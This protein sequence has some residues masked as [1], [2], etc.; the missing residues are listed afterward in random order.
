MSEHAVGIGWIRKTHQQVIF[1]HRAG[2]SRFLERHDR[3]LEKRDAKKDA[4]KKRVS[5]D[6]DCEGGGGSGSGSGKRKRRG[7]G[8]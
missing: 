3:E 8:V 6:V 7:E 1:R 2:S 5:D 4:G